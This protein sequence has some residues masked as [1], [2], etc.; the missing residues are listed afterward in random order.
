M[1]KILALFEMSRPANAIIALVTLGAGYFLSAVP[2]EGGPGFTSLQ[3]LADCIAMAL[4]IA[5]ANIHNDILDI[6]SDRINRPDRPLPAGLITI[7]AAT[8]GA[9]ATVVM[10][11]AMALLPTVQHASHL[12]F[13]TALFAGL[14][15]YNRFLK[16]VPLLK[17]MVVAFMCTTPLLRMFLYSDFRF[18]PLYPA[19]GFAFLYTLAR[20]IVKDLEDVSGDMKAGICTFPIAAGEAKAKMLATMLVAMTWLLLPA[21]ALFNWY[22][23]TFLLALLPLTPITVAIII[24]IFK[25]NFHKASKLIK[26][27]MFCGLVALLI[28][29]AIN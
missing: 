1:Q 7:R 22:P 14:F 23:A 4:A 20:E 25:K 21:P 6:K 11:L 28:A 15:L 18:E 5:F 16:H 17:N 2:T 8:F 12:I 26:I 3:L 27:A 9:I 10:A 19:I 13:Y 29:K 24:S